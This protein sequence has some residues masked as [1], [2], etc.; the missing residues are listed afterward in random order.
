MTGLSGVQD[1]FQRYL[2]TGDN[3]IES[4]VVGTERVPIS[5]RLAIYGDGYSSRLV[6]ALQT[7]FPVLAEL[8]GEAEFQELGRQYVRSHPSTYASIRD[9]GSELANFL[10][11]EERYSKAPLLAELARWEWAMATVFDAADVTP[12]GIEAFA[13]V[14]PEDWA[15]LWFQCCPCVHVLDLQW[16]VAPLWKAVTENTARPEPQLLQQG[17]WLLWRTGLQIFFRPLQAAEAAAL[18][19]A[20]EARSFGDICGLLCE[21]FDEAQA[22]AHAAG[23]LRGWVESGLIAAVQTRQP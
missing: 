11:T 6:E 4:H 23:F 20:R 21:H 7:T 2:L 16:N 19:A 17:H 15:N 9:Y 18:A 22:A 14:A 5:T 8:A 1:A 12:V 13:A 10:A 3:A